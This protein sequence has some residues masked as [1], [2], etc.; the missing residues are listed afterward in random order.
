MTLSP[1]RAQAF[2]VAQEAIKQ[3]ITLA[4]GIFA[5]TLTFLKDFTSAHADKTL[6]EIAWGAYLVSVLFGVFA[7]MC[8]ADQLQI[9][10]A[11]KE[12]TINSNGVKN[13]ALLQAL[14]FIVALLLTLIFGI[15]YA[16]V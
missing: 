13:C 2:T 8:L 6:L 9:T 4:T 16:K 14:L 5:L 10:S 1:Q 15:E 3:E 7:L 12:P 11:D